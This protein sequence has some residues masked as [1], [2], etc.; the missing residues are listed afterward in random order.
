ML[1]STIVWCGAV[2]RWTVD[3]KQAFLCAE[4]ELAPGASSIGF[5]P[6]FVIAKSIGTS[7]GA[8]RTCDSVLHALSQRY[9]A[10]FES[11]WLSWMMCQHHACTG[12]RRCGKPLRNP[13]QY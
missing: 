8:A 13:R 4:F 3:A 1:A 2:F 5:G 12:V 6:G 10:N 7:P 9:A 11:L